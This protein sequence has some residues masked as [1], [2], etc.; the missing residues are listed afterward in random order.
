MLH[1]LNPLFAR[2]YRLFGWK[3]SGQ[4]PD[5]PKSILI[6]APHATWHDFLV[7]VGARAYVDK[8][9]HYLGKAELFNAPFGGLFKALGGYPVER[10]KRN[11]LVD[12]IVSLYQQKESFHLALAPEGTR[13]DVDSLKT[14]FYYIAQKAH[15]PII[16]VGVDY[17]QKTIFIAEPFY[18]SQDLT[19]DMQHIARFYAQLPGK[20]KAWVRAMLEG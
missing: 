11:N 13:K 3:I 10:T 2:L 7:G 19:A 18:C 16:M 9:I 5:I 20:K 14:G 6:F 15:I 4:I 8:P 1:K 17:A 12:W